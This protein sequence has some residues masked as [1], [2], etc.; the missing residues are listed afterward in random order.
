MNWIDSFM[1]IFGYTRAGNT[2]SHN[3]VQ[4]RYKEAVAKGAM[5][6]EERAVQT[7]TVTK[8]EN[9]TSFGA[10]LNR[11]EYAQ[12]KQWTRNYRRNVIRSLWREV[13]DGTVT[14]AQFRQFV[15]MRTKPVQTERRHL[16]FSLPFKRMLFDALCQRHYVN[17]SEFIAFAIHRHNAKQDFNGGRQ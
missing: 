16:T 12:A 3:N 11:H 8:R 9:E 13:L 17:G 2:L 4:R 10:S 5:R 14:E 7:Q 6:N 15:K 1:S